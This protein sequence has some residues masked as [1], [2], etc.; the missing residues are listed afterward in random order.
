MKKLILLLSL[1][2]VVLFFANAQNETDALRYSFFSPYGTAKYT[3]MGGAFG[4]VGADFSSLSS[5]PAGIGVFNSNEFSFTPSFVFGNTNSNFLGNNNSDNKINLMIGNLGLVFAWDANKPADT[6]DGFQKF[7]LGFGINKTADFNNRFLIQGTNS[8]SSLMTDWVN[9][10]NNEQYTP[11]NLNPFD[12]RL[13]YDAYLIDPVAPDSTSYSSALQNGGVKQTKTAT[14]SGSANEFVVSG[15]AN[16]NNKLYLG[17]TLGV[18]YFDYDEKSNYTENNLNPSNTIVKNFTVTDHL[19]D[20][21][22]GINIKLGLIYRIT[23]WFRLGAAYHSPSFYKVSRTFD[24]SI[25]SELYDGSTYNLGSPKADLTYKFQTPSHYLGSAAFI[26]GKKGL[27]DIDYEYVDY[28]TMKLR[29]GSDGYDFIN[30]NQSINNI[31]KGQNNLRIGGEIRL[32]PVVLR[33]G[34]DYSSTPYSSSNN[35]ERRSVS[36]G[37]GFK[38][39]NAYIDLGFMHTF[40][41]EDYYLYNPAFVSASVNGISANTFAISYI[42]KFQ[43]KHPDYSKN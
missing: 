18:P 3:G 36:L 1:N 38:H 41:N 43:S 29:N 31:Y 2:L 16:Y 25:Y 19:T 13:A 42:Y 32:N 26:F 28:S 40:F 20:A 37:I 8:K 27:I 6:K 10:A 21:G 22:T 4:S 23:D 11:P 24:R 9:T 34:F 7:Q 30:E 14:F 17:I 33:A 15:G 12:T 35:D 39:K 5:N